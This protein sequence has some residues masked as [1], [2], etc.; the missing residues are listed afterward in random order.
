MLSE[1]EQKTDVIR[2][3]N[4]IR[5]YAKSLIAYGAIGGVLA[6]VLTFFI[7]KEFKSFG[8]VYPPSSTS[9]DNSID[10]PN[11]G[12]DVEADRLIQIL[13]STEIRDSVIRKFGLAGYFEIDMQSADWMDDLSKKYYK[14]IKFE[15]MPSMSIL[16]T[17]RTKDP[18]LSADIVN[19]ILS[20]ADALR[21][22]IY[23]KNIVTAYNNAKWDYDTQK[24]LVDS[25]QAVLAEKLKQNNMSSLLILLS[26]AQISFDLDKLNAI[27]STAANSSIG[28]DII[29]FKSMYEIFKEYKTRFIKIKKTYSNPIPTLYVINSAEANHKKISPSFIV[30]TAVGILFALAVATMVLLIRH[31]RE[32][33]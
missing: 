12:Y 18:R 19:Y 25:L 9:I 23:K 15:R 7:P 33:H 30:N 2:F 17:A 28:P 21:E 24:H 22:K 8:V 4:F 6:F 5:K 11:F 10:Y 13:A 16:V 20:S 3:W 1:K 26:D 32:N 31:S 29:A 27:G 14:N